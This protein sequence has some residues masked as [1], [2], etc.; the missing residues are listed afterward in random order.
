[1][2]EVSPL[3]YDRIRNSG[4]ICSKVEISK[5]LHYLSLLLLHFFEHE[6]ALGGGGGDGGG[7]LDTK[8]IVIV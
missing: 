4:D 1:M 8:S 7:I 3:H 6:F 5:M 2:I